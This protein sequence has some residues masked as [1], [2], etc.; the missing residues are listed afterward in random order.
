MTT[1]HPQTPEQLLARLRS[2]LLDRTWIDFKLIDS[3]PTL[4]ETNLEALK[5]DDDGMRFWIRKIALVDVY[6]DPFEDGDPLGTFEHW[7]NGVWTREEL[8]A[9]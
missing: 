9:V 7:T 4:A 8:I 1:D 5:A 6:A 3:W 2:N